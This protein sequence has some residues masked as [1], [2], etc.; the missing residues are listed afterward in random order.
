MTA[1]QAALHI[2]GHATDTDDARLLLTML[3]LVV[4]GRLVEPDP[5]LVEVANPKRVTL[6]GSDWRGYR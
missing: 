3:G 6:V 1:R 4:D 2:C 5:A